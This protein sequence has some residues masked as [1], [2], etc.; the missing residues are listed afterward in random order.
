[1]NKFS[2]LLLLLPAFKPMAPV[3]DSMPARHVSQ[4]MDE[5]VPPEDVKGIPA[6]I[7]GIKKAFAYTVSLRTQ[8]KLD[9]V[10]FSY[11]CEETSGTIIY[12]YEAGKLRM[13]D[14]GYS[15]GDHGGSNEQYFIKDTT[16]YFVYNESDSWGFEPDGIGTVDHIEETR[17]YIVNKQPV[18][19]LEKNYF[20]HSRDKNYPNPPDSIQNMQISCPTYEE[21]I[22]PYQQILRFRNH[23]SKGCWEKYPY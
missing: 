9:S 8:N 3:Q 18:R 22:A 10:S 7:M 17:T 21:I 19:C 20:A 16:L 5:D 1:M 2:L 23:P 13:I 4:K 15:E 11:S 6:D 12:F 14:Y